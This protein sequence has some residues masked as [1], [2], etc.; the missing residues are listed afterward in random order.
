MVAGQQEFIDKSVNLTEVTT[1]NSRALLW[2]TFQCFASPIETF[3]ASFHYLS[4]TNNISIVN[5]S[6]RSKWLTSLLLRNIAVVCITRPVLSL[7]IS[8]SSKRMLCKIWP[9]NICLLPKLCP[10]SVSTTGNRQLCWLVAILGAA[11]AA[12]LLTNS[13]HAQSWLSWQWQAYWSR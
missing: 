5:T 8:I 7:P 9:T 3:L 13:R 10:H 2:I 11:D 12:T 4:S 1:R 6:K